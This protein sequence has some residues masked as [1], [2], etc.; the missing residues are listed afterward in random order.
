MKARFTPLWYFVIIFLIGLLAGGVLEFITERSGVS[1]LGVPWYILV[2][3]FVTGLVILLF[4][5]QVR[6]YTRGDRKEI[7]PNVAVN[8]L[9]MS[10]ALSLSCSGLAGWYAGQLVMALP[11]IQLDYYRTAVIQ[12]ASAVVVCLLDVVFG[13]I[14]EHWCQRPP[15]DGPENPSQKDKDPLRSYQPPVAAQE[16]RDR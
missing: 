1:L 7:N 9:I 2:I 15:E 6:R 3:L 16:G 5:Y 14:G 12:C 11:R 10:K 13:I 8:A 4:A